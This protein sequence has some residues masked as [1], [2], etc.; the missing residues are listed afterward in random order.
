MFFSL[1]KFYQ[2]IHP[3]NVNRQKSS[4]KKSIFY[5]IPHSLA[6]RVYLYIPSIH[7]ISFFN[8]KQ[9]TEFTNKKALLQWENGYIIMM[10]LRLSQSIL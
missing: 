1:K 10:V 5:L 6:D 7:Y 8:E 4:L 3:I 9:K 2:T